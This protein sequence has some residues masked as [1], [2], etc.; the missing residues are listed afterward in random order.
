MMLTAKRFGE[1]SI[2]RAAS[3]LADAAAVS[4][5]VS[6]TSGFRPIVTGTK[7]KP[8]PRVEIRLHEK[9]QCRPEED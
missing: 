3:P 7:G 8:A 6:A 5:L 2:Y 4:G 9:D 1:V